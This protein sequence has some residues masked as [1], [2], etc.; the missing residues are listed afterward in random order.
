MFEKIKFIVKEIS[1]KKE[2][3]QTVNLIQNS[4]FE[5]DRLFDRASYSESYYL[6]LRVNPSFFTDNYADIDRMSGLIRHYINTSSE[7]KIDKISIKPNYERISVLNSEISIIE[8]PWEEINALQ[9]Q[10]IEQIKVSVNSI[11]FQNIGNT[12]RTLMDKIAR[13]VFNP[14]IHKPSIQNIDVSNGKFK[15]QLHTYISE[16]LKGGENQELRQF[17]K[18]AVDFTEDAIDLMNQTTHKL[19]VRKHFAEVCIISTINIVSLIKAIHE[20]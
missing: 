18:S 7:L 17:S 20:M 12:S 6:T 11:D 4:E 2:D 8:T 9:K 5:F 3:Y 15:N 14:E 13:L 19:D 10:L 1:K 16:T